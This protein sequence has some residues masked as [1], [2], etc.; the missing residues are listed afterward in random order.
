MV[1]TNVTVKPLDETW[2]N[3]AH[4]SFE[5]RKHLLNS[6]KSLERGCDPVPSFPLYGTTDANRI[7]RRFLASIKKY[8]SE[9]PEG[10]LDYEYDRL[11]K[12][13]PQGGFKPWEED[14]AELFFLYQSRLSAC[15]VDEE[16]LDEFL[17][18]YG[19]IHPKILGIDL[20]LATLVAASKIQTRAAGCRD[21]NLKKTD[22]L[23]QRRA[24]ADIRSGLYM[25]FRMYT[26][27]RYYKLKTRIFFPGPFANMIEQ[28]AY[29]HPFIEELQGDIL[30]KRASS[31]LVQHADKLGFDLCF[32]IMSDEINEILDKHVKG[33]E[34]T[35]IYVQGDFEK[36]DT[37]TGPAQYLNLFLP[38]LK[39]SFQ[40]SGHAYEQM[41]QAMLKT[42]NMPII[43]PSGVMFGDHGTGSGMDNTNIGEGA[44]NDYYQCRTIKILKILCRKHGIPKFY[45]IRRINGDDSAYIFILLTKDSKIVDKFKEL[46]QEAAE[47]A[48]SECGF[49]IN[50]K[51]RIDTNFGLFC[52]NGFYYDYKIRKVRYMY[53]ATLIINSIM[54][55]QT[56]YPKK[57]W[58]N[59]FIDMRVTEN[60]DNGKGLPYFQ[61]LVKYVD[62]G[63][64]YKLFRH[65][66]KIKDRILAKYAKYSALQPMNERYNRRDYNIYESP[67]VRIMAALLN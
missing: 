17:A 10:W 61:D 14:A 41:K 59:D 38:A 43:S 20:T 33:K 6:M 5:A 67:T 24:L 16:T 60:L 28:A 4:V 32:N 40:V 1:T 49:R 58:D 45:V 57:Q 46:I 55:P 13:G 65:S 36:M 3:E 18:S 11:S 12:V 51:W 37:T 7:I 50:E 48:A 29:I 53:P 42:V 21:F 9:L 44:C 62:N 27:L 25:Y 35:I 63:M 39:E 23:A 47:Q 15:F 31:T 52:Q 2:F 22:K 54:N 8:N 64:K 26:F 66:S 30:R 34:H 19:F 56:E